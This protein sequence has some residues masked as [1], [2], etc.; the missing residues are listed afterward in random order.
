MFALWLM[1]CYHVNSW[2]RRGSAVECRTLY[3]ESP[4]SNPLHNNGAVDGDTLWRQQSK[5][6]VIVLGNKL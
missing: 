5:I 2:R 6:L 1:L 3:R 4:G